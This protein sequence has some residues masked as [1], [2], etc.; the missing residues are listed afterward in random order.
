MS[1]LDI[2]TE[3]ILVRSPSSPPPNEPIPISLA[4]LLAELAYLSMLRIIPLSSKII[5]KITKLGKFDC[6]DAR[7]VKLD[8]Y[9]NTV[10]LVWWR[11]LNYLQ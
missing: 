4:P 5:N 6:R 2:S 7:E 9:G 10:V 8:L 11:Y 1:I 3:I